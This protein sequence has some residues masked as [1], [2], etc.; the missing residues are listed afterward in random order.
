MAGD[1]RIHSLLRLSEAWLKVWKN[2]YAQR[3][4][5]DSLQG[6]PDGSAASRSFSKGPL[7]RTTSTSSPRGI[8]KSSKMERRLGRIPSTRTSGRRIFQ[9]PETSGPGPKNIG[10]KNVNVLKL[11][12]ERETGKK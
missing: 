9:L 3:R 12:R 8:L 7:R 11:E 5:H 1:M 2:V 6:A 4:E 10:E